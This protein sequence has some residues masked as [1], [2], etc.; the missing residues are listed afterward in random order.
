[1]DP[2]NYEVIVG[3]VNEGHHWFLVVSICG[4]EQFHL[5]FP[6]ILTSNYI[7]LSSCLFACYLG[8]IPIPTKNHSA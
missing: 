5:N 3:I 2:A 7:T 1:L 8:Y 4:I 6:L